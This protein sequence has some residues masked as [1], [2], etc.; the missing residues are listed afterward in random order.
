MTDPDTSRLATLEKRVERLTSVLIIQSI[1]L[2]IT[3]LWSALSYAPIV[4]LVLLLSLPILVFYRR[5]LPG[6]ARSLGRFSRQVVDA[7]R[8]TPDAEGNVSSET[9][10]P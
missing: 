2:A 7:T 3:V 10:P 5:S 1:L 9:S 6:W 4:A 8:S